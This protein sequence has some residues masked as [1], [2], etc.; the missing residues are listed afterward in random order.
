MGSPTRRAPALEAPCAPAPSAQGTAPSHWL[1]TPRGGYRAWATGSPT[2]PPTRARPTNTSALPPTLSLFLFAH[3]AQ[4]HSRLHVSR[5]LGGR[6]RGGDRLGVGGGGGGRGGWRSVGRRGHGRVFLFFFVPREVVCVS[7]TRASLSVSIWLRLRRV[8]QRRRD[9]MRWSASMDG[10]KRTRRSNSRVNNSAVSHRRF[11]AA[12][13]LHTS[14]PRG[15]PPHAPSPRRPPLHTPHG[16]CSQ[17]PHAAGGQGERRGRG[18]RHPKKKPGNDVGARNENAARGAPALHTLPPAGGAPFY[19]S[20][21]GT[22]T[23]TFE[24]LGVG[25]RG[26]QAWVPAGRRHSSVFIGSVCRP[27]LRLRSR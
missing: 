13:L 7:E 24:P 25:G 9:E 4:R 16:V 23:P 21:P 15:T 19:S 20:G 10:C 2:P 26:P 6:L 14:A 3:L 8:S 17:P 18:E 22:V 1:A 27:P 5:H 11:R 12:P